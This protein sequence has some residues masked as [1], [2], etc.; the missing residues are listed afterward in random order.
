MSTATLSSKYQLSLPKA[1]REAM[2]LQPG[3]Q[4]ELIPTGSVIQLVP[5]TSIKELRGIACGANPSHYRDRKD[6]A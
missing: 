5:K 4:F 6:R 3:Q 2:H 1:L